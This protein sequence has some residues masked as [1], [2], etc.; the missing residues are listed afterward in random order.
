MNNYG[1]YVFG[2]TGAQIIGDRTLFLR[3]HDEGVVTVGASIM[4]NYPTTFTIGQSDI[5]FAPVTG[6]P[7]IT[8]TDF[9]SSAPS[10]AADLAQWIEFLSLDSNNQFYQARVFNSSLSSRTMKW[11]V[12]RY[13][14]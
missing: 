5:T 7:I 6:I 3:A 2:P 1:I 11:R 8:I 4:T 12:W 13:F 10:T 9:N 14:N